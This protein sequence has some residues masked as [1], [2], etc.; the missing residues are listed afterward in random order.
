MENKLELNQWLSQLRSYLPGFEEHCCKSLVPWTKNSIGNIEAFYYWAFIQKLKPNIVLESGIKHGRST[1]VLARACHESKSRQISFDVG[2]IIPEVAKISQTYHLTELRHE[3]SVSGFTEVI[4]N[5]NESVSFFIDG[6]KHEQG[7]R[8]I[9]KLASGY[10]G[11]TSFIIHD[12]APGQKVRKIFDRYSHLFSTEFEIWVPDLKFNKDLIRLNEYIRESA[13][14]CT[15]G[16]IE[17][18]NTTSQY[19]GICLRRTCMIS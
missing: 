19:I 5:S 15:S 8:D 12:C 1:H 14:N 16:I 4:Q 6:P 7:I 9:M 18:L 17:A 10:K 13:N 3:D 2:G 11:T